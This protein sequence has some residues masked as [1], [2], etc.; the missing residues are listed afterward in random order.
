MEHNTVKK[1]SYCKKR[2]AL[3]IIIGSLILLLL[4]VKKVW[5]KEKSPEDVSEKQGKVTLEIQCK[6]LSDDILQLKKAEKAQWVPED[7]IILEKTEYVV[8]KGDTVFDILQKACRE[9]KIQMEYS[10]IPVYESAYVEGIHQIY[11]FDAGKNSGWTYY[12]DGKKAE[13]GCSEYELEGGENILW[14][15]V[16][17]YKIKEEEGIE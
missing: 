12:V 2:L 3:L 10:Y 17:N 15:Y 9:N 16:C 11:E 13:Y 8:E 5:N 1:L 14:E 7:G 4:G 6:Q